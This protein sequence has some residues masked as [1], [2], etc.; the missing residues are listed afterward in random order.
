MSYTFTVKD[1]ESG[2]VLKEGSYDFL[3]LV[4][5]RRPVEADPSEDGAEEVCE[6]LVFRGQDPVADV[7][8]FGL[9]EWG[10]RQISQEWEVSKWTQF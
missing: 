9:L 5:A 3:A 7:T 2:E 10:K 1:D 4:G 6:L 8:T